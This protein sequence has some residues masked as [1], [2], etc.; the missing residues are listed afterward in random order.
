MSALITMAG[1]VVCAAV[2]MGGAVTALTAASVIKRLAGVLVSFISAALAI[3]VLGAP[4]AM[5]VGA[6]AL[7][8]AYCV[9]GVAVLVR[10]QEGYGVSDVAELDRADDQGE[11]ERNG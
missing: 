6:V 3:G 4:P 8:V 1:L 9:A 5:S 11:A 2:L 7:M 10:L